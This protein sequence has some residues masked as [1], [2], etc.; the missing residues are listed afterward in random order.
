MGWCAFQGSVKGLQYTLVREDFMLLFDVVCCTVVLGP[1]VS[2]VGWSGMPESVLGFSA[3]VPI[4]S[5]IH[6]FGASGLNVVVHNANGCCVVGL[7]WSGRLL[8]AHLLKCALLWNCGTAL[9]ALMNSAP[10]SASAAEDIIALISCARLRIA[11]LSI[12]SS[13][14]DNK[15]K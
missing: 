15:K 5:H 13:T 11:P 6:G 14:L 8:V 2:L 10:S 4:E 3:L 9:R 12:G 7:H 1:V